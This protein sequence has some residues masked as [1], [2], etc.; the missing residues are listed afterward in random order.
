MLDNL[1]V[2]QDEKSDIIRYI[3]ENYER[4]NELSLRVVVKL[5]Q[6]RKGDPIY[7]RE[8]ADVTELRRK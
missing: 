2:T 1:G 6:L 5:T 7:W 8:E 4:M 3:D